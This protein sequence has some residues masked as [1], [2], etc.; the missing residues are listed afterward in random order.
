MIEV[1]ST[2]S[3]GL[4]VFATQD[5]GI[6]D[7]I[8]EE[9]EPIL[10][11]APSSE[12]DTSKLL[13]ALPPVRK[14]APKGEVSFPASLAHPSSISKEYVG[15]FR[16]MIQAVACFAEFDKSQ[17]AASKILEL[18][19]PNPDS[20]VAEEE[21]IVKVSKEALK[22]VQNHSKGESKLR[23]FVTK[24]PEQAVKIML[25]WACNSYEGG[26]LYEIQCRINHSCNPNAIIQADGDKQV[27]RA[28]AEIKSGTEIKTSY[29]GLL[30][31]TDCQTRR[32]LLLSTKH[33]QC[34][35]DRCTGF[36]DPAA[37]IPCPTCHPRDGRYLEEDVAY[38]DDKQVKYM[39]P[40]ESTDCECVI[41]KTK[42]QNNNG[43]SSNEALSV[44]AVVS[45]KVLAHLQDKETREEDDDD[46]EA[47]EEW[48]QQMHQL[49]CS[50]VGAMHWTTNLVTLM[51]LNRVLKQQHV[52]MLQSGE[53]PAVEDIAEAIDMLERLCRFMEALKLNLHMG[54]L[55]SNVVVGVARTLVSLGD[56]K[57][58]KYAAEWVLK[59]KDYSDTFDS[60][61]MQKVVESLLEA[62]EKRDNEPATKKTKS[63]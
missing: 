46:E 63:N 62:W 38:D 47:D 13:A 49:T 30:L 25:V 1:R 9:A 7:V 19:A 2:P 18:Y 31:Y 10:R 24:N 6:G 56:E 41:C 48:E 35:C 61:G 45:K 60:D 57:S 3:G 14:G 37:A 21:I 36:E 23:T 34:T 22:Y 43:D 5:Y 39:Y 52:S 28:A 53:T 40:R 59:V 27:V 58:K 42:L 55:L 12:Q 8:V 16:G 4:G 54:H 32:A 11:L 17:E 20:T 15:Q 33:F 50:V 29:L 51:R 26:R 44:A